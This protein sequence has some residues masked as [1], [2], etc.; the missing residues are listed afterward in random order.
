M[1]FFGDE[2]SFNF[3]GLDPS[4]DYA[5]RIR[6]YENNIP[7]LW[8]TSRVFPT[9][10]AAFPKAPTAVVVVETAEDS[11]TLSWGEVGAN[12]DTITDYEIDCMDAEEDP[13]PEAPT[14]SGRLV[15]RRQ[16]RGGLAA[17]TAYSLRVR[18]VNSLG[19]GEWSDW[20]TSTTDD[21]P[22]ER[23]ETPP[24][25]VVSGTSFPEPPWIVGLI[26][27]CCRRTHT[28]LYLCGRWNPA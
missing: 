17:D 19:A 14:V 11:L 18:A 9:A 5:F 2:E 26:L 21:P 8:S 6:F 16:T 7:S 23:P 12:G 24:P 28:E 25:V 1:V 20:A 3:A 22:I 10:A 27:L 4:N 15:E 13:C